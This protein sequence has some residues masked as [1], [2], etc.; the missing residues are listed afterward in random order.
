MNRLADGRH[1]HTFR[2]SGLKTAT[3]CLE[4]ARM[5]WSGEMPNVES[6]AAAVGTAVH[7]ALEADLTTYR[8]MGEHFEQETLVE[9][10]NLEF[11]ELMAGPDFQW[12]KYNEQQAR[13]FGAKCVRHYYQEL[14]P[15]LRPVECELNFTV[16]LWEDDERV[17]DLT[18]TIDL[19]D[20]RLGIA[21]FKTSGGG[22]YQEW[23]YHRW[24]VQPTAYTYACH[25]LG[26]RD[27]SH[28]FTYLVMSKDGVQQFTV[29]RDPGWWR[30][31][32]DQ[33]VRL[34]RLAEADLE[35]WPTNDT[36]ALC[37]DKWCP[38]WSQCKG[39]HVS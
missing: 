39:Q 2:Q 15:G 19:I 24:A 8:D 23:Q 37:S 1:H 7:A 14:A 25:E 3:I 36:H 31:L 32:K 18:G 33:A 22:K 38:A 13:E 27:I 20:G 21:D 12:I 29:E 28:Q 16:P 35:R 4:R 9:L 5:E 10:F 30:W 17:I 26:M 34:A 11:S 6:D